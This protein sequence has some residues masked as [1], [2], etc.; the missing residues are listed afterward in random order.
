[1]VRICCAEMVS[2]SAKRSVSKYCALTCLYPSLLM[3][4]PGIRQCCGCVPQWC[5][6]LPDR[7]IRHRSQ[8]SWQAVPARCRCW[9]SPFTLDVLLAGLQRHAV[10][11]LTVFVFRPANDASRH[12]ALVLVAGGKV[13]CRRSAVEHRCTEPLCGS[14]D[15]VGPHS[16]GGV[17][18]ARLRMSAATATLQLAAWAFPRRRDNLPRCRRR[19]DIAV[20]R[21]RCPA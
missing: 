10:A 1:M 8:P 9:K 14:E 7:D 3:L 6:C 11:Q 5:G 21:R 12:I 15:D 4:F 2:G 16:P 19:W 17:S 18:R 13:G 20:R